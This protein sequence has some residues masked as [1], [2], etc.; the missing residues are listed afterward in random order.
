[1]AQRWKMGEKGGNTLALAFRAWRHGLQFNT[2]LHSMVVVAGGKLFRVPIKKRLLS[3]LVLRANIDADLVTFL[4]RRFSPQLLMYYCQYI[5]NVSHNYWK[6]YQ[7]EFF[8]DV[9]QKELH[10]TRVPLRVSTVPS[11]LV[12][13]EWP[14]A[15][16]RRRQCAVS[17]TMASEQR[18]KNL[19]LLPA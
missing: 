10:D 16:V 17:L 19:F 13:L 2:L 9:D 8:D 7:P 15:W 11:M 6:Y 12:C 1:M 14:L 18:P 5:D 3:K 4:V